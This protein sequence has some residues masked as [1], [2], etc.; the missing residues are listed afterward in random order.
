MSLLKTR[1]KV[2]T[3]GDNICYIP[4]KKG[5]RKM[6]DKYKYL[7]YFI[8]L[9]F[10]PIFMLGFVYEII[11]WEELDDYGLYIIEDIGLEK[12]SLEYAKKQIDFVLEEEQRL[13][14][15]KPKKNISYIKYP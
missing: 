9:L 7:Y 5:V 10:F 1:I 11:F 2:I 13:R 4:Q 14:L 12:Y 6:S 15:P 3:E 8:C